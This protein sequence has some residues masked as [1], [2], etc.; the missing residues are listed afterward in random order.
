[1]LQNGDWVG[2][3]TAGRHVRTDCDLLCVCL[4]N[5]LLKNKYLLHWQ[6]DFLNCVR[7]KN[8]LNNVVDTRMVSSISLSAESLYVNQRTHK[9]VW[10]GF[11]PTVSRPVLLTPQIYPLSTLVT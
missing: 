3:P 7:V 5:G 6:F 11:K 10:F 4:A 9:H 1:M 2:W 8:L